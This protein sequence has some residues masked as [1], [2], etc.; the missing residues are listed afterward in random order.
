MFSSLEKGLSFAFSRHLWV[1]KMRITEALDELKVGFSFSW[2]WCSFD[3]PNSWGVALQVCKPKHGG[4]YPARL[5]GSPWSPIFAP[6][7]F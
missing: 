7:F 6:S 2:S 3:F 4:V 1:L 5:L